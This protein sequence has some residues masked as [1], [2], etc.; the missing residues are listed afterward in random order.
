MDRLFE[1]WRDSPE[2]D[3][4]F[5]AWLLSPDQGALRLSSYEY[6]GEPNDFRRWLAER[7]ARKHG[8]R[9]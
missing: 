6:N 3:E 5:T 9:Q 4:A 2:F 1:E 7:E 8:D